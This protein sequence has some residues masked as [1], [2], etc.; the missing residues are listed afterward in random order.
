MKNRKWKEEQHYGQAENVAVANNTGHR[1]IERRMAPRI[2][3]L[4]HAKLRQGGWIHEEDLPAVALQPIDQVSNYDLNAANRVTQRTAEQDI[5]GR[6]SFLRHEW[7][8]RA[9]WDSRAG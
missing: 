9:R 3:P 2:G 6:W 7:W 1:T 5:C 8:S 4:G